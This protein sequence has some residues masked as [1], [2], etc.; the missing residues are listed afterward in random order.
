MIR[1][2]LLLISTALLTGSLLIATSLSAA[3]PTSGHVP[4]EVL[5]R[6]TDSASERRHAAD[7]SL[8]GVLEGTGRANLR[9]LRLP[10]GSSVSDVIKFMRTLDG[11]AVAQPNYRYRFAA[12]PNDPDLG[13]QW[14]VNNSG[15]VILGANYPFNNPGLPGSDLGLDA[16]W[17]VRSDCS[18]VVV[19]V[20]DSGVDYTHVDLA[21][22]MWDGTPAYPY[23]GWDTTGAGDDDPAPDTA[24]AKDN[25]GTHVAGIVAAVGDNGIGTTGVCQRSE[26]MAIRAGSFVTGLSTLDVIEAIAF[27]INNGAT[28]LNMSFGGELPF[29]PLFNAAIDDARAANVLVIAAAGND[30]LSVDGPGIDGFDAT[31]FYPCAFPQDNVV[32]VAASDQSDEWAV[33][34]N[35]G[36]SSVDVAAPGTNILST[37]Y[38]DGFSV[39]TGTSMATAQ[40]TGVAALIWAQNP[41]YSYRDVRAALLDETRPASA[42]T[43][44]TLT[45]GVIQ[46]NG[47]VRHLRPPTGLSFTLD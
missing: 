27:A 9:R 13:Q 2:R 45:G 1:A 35:F 46:A 38:F 4:G 6:F 24:I 11:V 36:A 44:L 12:L 20:I 16:A 15:Q 5:V 29:D 47:S 26:I 31:R 30:G 3:P 19:A 25:H 28:I 21:G 22:A 18:G 43:G 41:A 7:L 33:F 23:P 39:I 37:T 8:L 42:W 34:S 32:C 14:A 10:G 17:E 40:A